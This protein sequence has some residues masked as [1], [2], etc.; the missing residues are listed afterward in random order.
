MAIEQKIN[1][2]DLM[3]YEI[4]RNPALAIEFIYNY[5]L[6]EQDSPIEL[7]YY[8]FNPSWPF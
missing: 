1:F 6:T 8:H 5:D 2:E 3:L 7:V 4:L